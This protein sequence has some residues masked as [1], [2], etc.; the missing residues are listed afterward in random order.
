M[1][2]INNLQWIHDIMLKYK[3]IQEFNEKF[4]KL[5]ILKQI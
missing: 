5:R 2:K 1:N 4:E 3:N